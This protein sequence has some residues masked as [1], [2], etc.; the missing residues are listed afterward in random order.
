MSSSVTKVI[1]YGFKTI[2]WEISRNEV[3][4]NG[5]NLCNSGHIFNVTEFTSD[6]SS[7]IKAKCTPQHRVT[8]TPYN[9]EITVRMFSYEVLFNLI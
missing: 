8:A 1:Q 2:N 4:D 7:V 5:S 3:I 6:K 9:V